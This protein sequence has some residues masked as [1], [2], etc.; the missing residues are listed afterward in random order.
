PPSIASPTTSHFPRLLE[1][2]CSDTT[3]STLQVPPMCKR[4]AMALSCELQRQLAELEAECQA[5]EA[6]LDECMTRK[7]VNSQVSILA[8]CR[9]HTVFPVLEAPGL[10]FFNPPRRGDVY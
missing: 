1:M 6:A 3:H 2:L 5:Y 8:Y 4:C 7:A 10:V 9:R